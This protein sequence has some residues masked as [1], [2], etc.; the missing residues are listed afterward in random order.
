[1]FLGVGGR[2]RARDAEVHALVPFAGLIELDV[3]VLGARET[4][5]VE[6]RVA[7]DDDADA[8]TRI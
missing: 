3:D 4:E 2:Q 8:R 5:R 6:E 7:A 1:M